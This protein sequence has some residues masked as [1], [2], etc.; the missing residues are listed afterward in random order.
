MAVGHCG[1]SLYRGFIHWRCVSRQSIA[2]GS[3]VTY[4]RAYARGFSAAKRRRTIAYCPYEGHSDASLA[5]QLEW[6][7]GH[8]DAMTCPGSGRQRGTRWAHRK[9]VR[10][11]WPRSQYA[12]RRVLEELGIAREQT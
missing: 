3:L 4:S 1:D 9:I 10:T 11:R 2:V 8:F 6:M 12:R 7:T 5:L